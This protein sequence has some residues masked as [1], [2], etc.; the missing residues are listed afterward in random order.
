MKELAKTIKTM[1]KSATID[2]LVGEMNGAVQELQNDL[3]SLSYLLNP[4]P[5]VENTTQLEA[6]STV[7][8]LMEIIPAVTLAS[9]LIETAV[10]IE[11]LIDAVEE[12]AKLA[13][14][15]TNDDKSKQS[16][17]KDKIVPNESKTEEV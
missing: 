15:T 9:I 8:P 2:L 7:V 14:F 12:L 6:T 3:K 11:A 17:M 16:K 10:R 13:E 5:T 4:S 1:K